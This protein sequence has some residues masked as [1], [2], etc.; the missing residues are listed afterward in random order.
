MLTEPVA[1]V[2]RQTRHG[3]QR[4]GS[5]SVAVP[6]EAAFLAAH[7]HVRCWWLLQRSPGV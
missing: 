2:L 6:S 3:N 7:R 5:G 4:T 1:H